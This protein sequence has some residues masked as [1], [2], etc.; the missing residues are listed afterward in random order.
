MSVGFKTSK[1][2]VL[3]WKLGNFYNSVS[4]KN[5]ADSFLWRF[6]VVYASAHEHGKQEF[7]DELH[8]VLED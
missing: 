2:E 4:I 1:L 5:T 3:S 7:I 8:V 6:I